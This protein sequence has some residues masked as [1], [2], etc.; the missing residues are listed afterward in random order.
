MRDVRIKRCV[1]LLIAGGEASVAF[2]IGPALAQFNVK[3]A[4]FAKAFNEV[5]AE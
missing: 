3:A 2:P 5:T 1:N 4:D